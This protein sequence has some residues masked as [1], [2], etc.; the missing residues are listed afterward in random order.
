MGRSVSVGCNP[1]CAELLGTLGRKAGLSGELERLRCRGP[2]ARGGGS[3]LGD[4]SPYRSGA[5]GRARAGFIRLCADARPSCVWRDITGSPRVGCLCLVCGGKD[6]EDFQAGLS[7]RLGKRRKQ[8]RCLGPWIGT[9]TLCSVGID[10]LREGRRSPWVTR[11]RFASYAP[12]LVRIRRAA[13]TNSDCRS[14]VK[15]SR[16]TFF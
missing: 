6:D 12:D 11:R 8:L 16:R 1:T 4:W 7:T 3:A 5:G 2:A 10:R 9:D 13:E 14:A 15:T